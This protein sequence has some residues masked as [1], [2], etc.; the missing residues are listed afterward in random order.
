MMLPVRRTARS[1]AFAAFAALAAACSGAADG[2]A[3]SSTIASTTTTT[4]T[5]AAPVATPTTGP[6][7][8]ARPPDEAGPPDGRDE[9]GCPGADTCGR[10]AIGEALPMA[11]GRVVVRYRINPGG[12]S[13]PY[14]SEDQRVAAIR[15][16]AAAWSRADPRIVFQYDGLTTKPAGT[17][18]VAGFGTPCNHGTHPA[19]G[20]LIDGQATLT[21][22]DSAPWTWRAC[23]PG[24]GD[25]PCTPYDQPC[26]EIGPDL[27]CEGIDLQAVATH[28]W[29]H[30]LGLRDLFGR[31][32]TGLTMYARSPVADRDV[33]RARRDLSTLGRGDILGLRSLY[34]TTVPFPA[35]AVP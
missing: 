20:G 34:P 13:T 21:F 24:G 22:S 25:R 18:G 15:A 4:T 8:T 14:I 16:A 3:A 35:I 32:A 23:G 30:V 7:P 31:E 33:D 10:F 17:P 28:E 9:T 29:G 1:T 6:L 19:C 11:G 5:T 12:S 26:R 2:D 27:R